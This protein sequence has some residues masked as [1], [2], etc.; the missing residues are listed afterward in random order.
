MAGD[1]SGRR[2]LLWAVAAAAAGPMAGFAIVLLA[3]PL[4]GV[5]G[6]P[7]A[8]VGYVALTAGVLAAIGVLPAWQWRLLTTGRRVGVAA[9]LAGAGAVVAGAISAI[10]A[11]TCG[12]LVAGALSGPLLVAARAVVP[13]REFYFLMATG[14]LAG[15]ALAGT[16]AENPGLPLIVAGGVAATAGCVLAV[17]D[18]PTRAPGRPGSAQRGR[19]AATSPGSAAAASPGNAAAAP[20]GSAAA[21]SLGSAAIVSFGGGESVETVASDPVIPGGEVRVVG[22]AVGAPTGQPLRWAGSCCAA[23]GFVMGATILPALHLLLFRWKVLDAHQCGYVGAALAVALVVASVRG[24]RA[25]ALAPLL[26]LAA[27]GP[28]LV[29]T[30]P[31]PWRLTVGMAVSVAATVRV[32]ATVD[33]L[34][35]QQVPDSAVRTYSAVTALAFA[36]GAAAG[37]GAVAGLSR[38]WGTGTALTLASIPVLAAA[39][40]TTR[41][42]P[43]PGSVP[44][45]RTATVL[46]IEGGAR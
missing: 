9:V 45:A 33:S 7:G 41:L 30:A 8:V 39:V 28:L 11:L 1:C 12:V 14:G 40:L 19:V 26:I 31:G 25:S 38:W 10:P 17:F 23:V 35:R 13:A 29:A 5:V 24:Y 36:G 32:L 16:C 18:P 2:G 37:L 21:A 46:P 43:H 34:V 27:G 20:P 6:L 3:K 42:I 22:V 44:A 15:A 4:G